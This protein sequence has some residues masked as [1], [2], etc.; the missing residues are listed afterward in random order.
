MTNGLETHHLGRRFGDH[1]AVRD[2]TMTVEPGEVV[3]FLGDNG[4]G[5]TTTIRMVLG[6]LRAS[7]GSARILGETVPAP[8]SVM[9]RVGYLDE[10][11]GFYASLSARDNLRVVLEP[12]GITL[13]AIDEALARVGLTPHAKRRTKALSHGMKTRLGIARAIADRPELVVLDEP[14]SGLDPS[15]LREFRGI[16]AELAAAGSAV[17]FSS[18]QLDEVERVCDRVVVLFAGVVAGERAMRRSGTPEAAFV[19]HV[20]PA[21]LARAVEA[22]APFGPT[23]S[24]QAITLTAPSGASVSE[25]LMD[26][27]IPIDSLERQHETLEAEFFAQPDDTVHD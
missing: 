23:V 4:A 15:W 6:L 21:N 20:A 24:D 10:Q 19:V 27:G 8:V 13:S 17:L 14:T 1:W 22:L 25:A 5:K 7:E 11:P 18:H 26:A 16:V 9:R 3:G 12:V 2:L